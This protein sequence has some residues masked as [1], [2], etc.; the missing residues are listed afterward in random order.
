MLGK[1]STKKKHSRCYNEGDITRNAHPGYGAGLNGASISTFRVRSLVRCPRCFPVK[2]WGYLD[3][4]RHL[5]DR[6]G[7]V[8]RRRSGFYAMGFNKQ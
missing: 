3:I 5:N 2:S 6:L 7:S 8:V 4:S 1:K